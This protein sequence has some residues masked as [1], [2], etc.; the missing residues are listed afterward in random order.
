MW[1]SAPRTSTPGRR[2]RPG[3]RSRACG[4]AAGRRPAGCRR[5]GSR[6]G[7]RGSGL[8]HDPDRRRASCRDPL[9]LPATRGNAAAIAAAAPLTSTVLRSTLGPAPPVR[10]ARGQ[11]RRFPEDTSLLLS[12]IL[13]SDEATP[14]SRRVQA[15][16]SEGRESALRP[17]VER[18][19]GLV[20]APVFH[21]AAGSQASL[22]KS[23]S[24][25]ART[26][27]SFVVSRQSVGLVGSLSCSPWY[28]GV[29]VHWLSTTTTSRAWPSRW[30]SRTSSSVRSGAVGRGLTAGKASSAVGGPSSSRPCWLRHTSG[31]PSSSRGAGVELELL[32]RLIPVVPR[33]EERGGAGQLQLLPARE[34]HHDL[35]ALGGAPVAS[36]SC[37]R[38]RRSCRPWFVPS[39]AAVAPFGADA[40]FVGMWTVTVSTRRPGACRRG[41]GRDRT[42]SPWATRS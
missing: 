1:P 42:R 38:C 13:R 11:P 23:S 32:Q 24:S 15:G 3:R 9:R 20:A 4:G 37:S 29:P 41:T 14:A 21:D 17:A 19:I 8:G 5:S 40:Q 28:D 6:R 25:L 26:D 31:W 34:R 2:N 7:R 39:P 22:E 16:T 36:S 35:P 33:D 10:H 27:S 18:R 30:R 12:T